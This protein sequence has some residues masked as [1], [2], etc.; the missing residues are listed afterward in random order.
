[1]SYYIDSEDI[2]AA[3][4]IDFDG[5]AGVIIDLD[6]NTV[7]D[8]LYSFLLLLVSSKTIEYNIEITIESSNTAPWF[9]KTSDSDLQATYKQFGSTRTFVLPEIFD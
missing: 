5:V 2:D 3:S 7:S 6:S 1:M 9:H 8:G 4:F